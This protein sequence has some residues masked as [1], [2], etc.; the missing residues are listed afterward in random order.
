MSP[1]LARIVAG[2]KL[3]RVNAWHLGACS[4]S[5]FLT[6]E[7]PNMPVLRFSK[8]A[9]ALLTAAVMGYG[10]TALAQGY[11]PGMMGGYGPGMMQGYGPGMMGGYGPGYGPGMMHGYGPGMMGGYGPGYG[12]GMM[13]GYGPGMMGP[14]YGPGM[15]QGYGPG[16]GPGMRGGY[17]RQT[18]QSLSV[19]D[20]KNQ[21]ERWLA[22]RGNPRLKVGEVKEKDSNTIEADIVTRDNSLVQ[23]FT[24]DRKSGFYRPD[25]GG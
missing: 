13:Q 9:A 3:T 23:R 17:Q 12:P 19:D 20:V 7:Y 5:R 10:S 11:G 14:G 6:E 2:V 22:W 16:Y 8:S 25:T 4:M 1:G 15:M 18:D 24:V 21:L